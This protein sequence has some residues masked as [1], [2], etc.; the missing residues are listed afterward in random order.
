MLGCSDTPPEDRCTSGDDCATGEVCI[1]GDCSPRES[2]TPGETRACTCDGLSGTQACG[3]SGE[4][5]GRC[6]CS[7]ADAGSQDGGADAAA[8]DAGPIDCTGVEPAGWSLCEETA[9]SCEIDVSDGTG[10]P[11]ACAALGLRCGESFENIDGMCAPDSTLP[12]LNCE[13]TGHISD[14][15]V[16]VRGDL[17]PSDAGVDGGA[18]DGGPLDG[19]LDGG[20]DGGGGGSCPPTRPWECI[21]DEVEGFGAATTGGRGG[22]LCTVSTLASGGAGSLRDCLSAPGRWIVFDVSGVIPV[23]ADVPDNTTIDGRGQRV[24]LSGTASHVVSI[25][26]SNVLLTHL[27]IENATSDGVHVWPTARNVWLNHLSLSDVDDELLGIDGP[28]VTVSWCHLRDNGYATL[29]G[30][31]AMP[32]PEL[33]VTFHHNHFSDNRERHPRTRGRVHFYNN[34]VRFTGSGGRVSQNGHLLSERNIYV[35]TAGGPALISRTGGAVTVPGNYRSF[36]DRLGGG[37]TLDPSNDPTVVFDARDFYEYTLDAADEALEAR[38]AAEAGWQD[39][40][41]PR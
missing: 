26:S 21:L 1:N 34:F 28:T 7:D 19:G 9:S 4:G 22:E 41:F 17:P 36:E 18:L 3:P 15:C 31:A 5:F 37:A 39:V 40:P 12:P 13:E 16:C 10:C 29:V 35:A 30:G 27:F 8:P 33:F 20:V 14:Y 25:G 38:V 24:T 23:N 32:Y 11:A 2:C 6:T